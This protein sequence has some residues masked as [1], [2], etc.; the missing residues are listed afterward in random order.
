MKT[1]LITGV[2][3]QD[4]SFLAKLLLSKGY[5]VFGTTRDHNKINFR[6]LEV[7]E[8]KSNIKYLLVRS[9]SKSG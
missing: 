7:L 1:A 4:G 9:T 3:G 8:V 5:R 6:N 2:S